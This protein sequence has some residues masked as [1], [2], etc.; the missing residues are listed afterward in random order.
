MLLSLLLC[1]LQLAEHTPHIHAHSNGFAVV[2]RGTVC[3]CLMVFVFT[4]CLL[5]STEAFGCLLPLYVCVCVGL[6]RFGTFRMMMYTGCVVPSEYSYNRPWYAPLVIGAFVHHPLN[7][8]QP[9][10]SNEHT[11]TQQYKLSAYVQYLM[12]YKQV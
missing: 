2:I 5:M 8:S 6:I 7:T 4:D 1:N 11:I 3:V 10:R 9:D 12:E